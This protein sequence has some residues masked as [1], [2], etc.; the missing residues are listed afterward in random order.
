MP[1]PRSL[2]PIL[3]LL[4]LRAAPARAHERW[5]L[6]PERIDSLNA[7]PKPE[8][9]TM[10]TVEGVAILVTFAALVGA[11]MSLHY[12]PTP[13]WL[14]SL[15]GRT[16]RH[17]HYV[18]A[19]LRFC[20]A[21]TLLSSAFGLEPQVGIAPLT[22]PSF[23]A[24]DLL[25]R[26]LGP[27][28]EWLGPLQIAVALWLIAGC[29]AQ[30]AGLALITLAVAGCALWGMAM[31]AYLPVWAGVGYYLLARGGGHYAWRP[32]ALAGLSARFPPLLLRYPQLVL[33]V[34]TG[35][36]F[37]Y[38]GIAFK[39]MQPNLTVAIIT[40]YHVPIL[41][42]APETFVFLMAM[43]ETTGGLLILAG[44]MIRIVS[45]GLLCAFVFFAAMLPES[46][47]VHMLYYGVMVAFLLLGPGRTSRAGRYGMAAK[48][49]AA[50]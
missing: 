31:A 13:R 3:L 25:I 33:R 19:I 41:S 11:L 27:G 18:P 7:Q 9:F 30:G 43:I 44:I 28:W 1:Y 4:A 16:R 17:A 6:G 22:E 2:A 26:D 8:I 23:L 37:L 5:I 32:R 40:T 39:F 35:L 12:G 50:A 36:G 20:A 29:G 47:T 14:V 15:S 49:V 48:P 34:L 46:L 21:W 42:L 10:V 38:L 45:A 24:P